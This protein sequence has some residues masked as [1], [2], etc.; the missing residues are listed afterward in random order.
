[1]PENEKTAFTP[2]DDIYGKK[3][4]V[5]PIPEK[6][7]GIDT[8]NSF[9]TTLIDSSIASTLDLSAF[10]SF[11]TTARSRDQVYTLI[12]QMSEDSTIAAVL[13][14]YAE[15]ATETNENG[16]I[17]WAESADSDISKYINYLLKAM[18]V[19]KNAYGW[20]HSLCKY[21]DLYL[22]LYRESEYDD[23]LLFDE[24]KN[25]V[26][27]RALNEE[28]NLNDPD[29]DPD[30]TKQQ[31]NED[32]KI[33]A[34]KENDHYVHYVEMIPNPAEMF[35]LTK[36][37]KTY[38]YIQSEVNTPLVNNRDWFQGADFL[39]YSFKRN[40]IKVY[41]AT[42]FV[43]AYLEDNTNRTPEEVRITFD[44]L[45]DE[46]EENAPSAT[47]KVRR[48]QSLLYNIFKIWRELQL[49]ENSILL[50]R[51]T[52]SAVT[53]VLGIEVGDMPKEMV[54]PHLQGVKSLI[55]QKSALNTD[56]SMNEYTNP[57]PIENTVYIPTRNGI[58]AINMQTI[59]GDVNVGELTDLE[60][61]R[62]KLF[63][64]LRVPKQFFGFTDD[65][66]GFSG[67]QSLS[68]ISSRYAKMIIRIQNTIVQA[69]T[70]IVNL[71]LLDRGLSGYINKFNIKMQKPV[72]QD[73]IDRRD[74]LS[75]NNQVTGDIMNLI[76]E[77]IEDPTSKLEILKS[78]LS[79]YLTNPEVLDIIQQEINKLEA[80]AEEEEAPTDL[81]ETDLDTIEDNFDLG[82]TDS[83]G[84][85]AGLDAALGLGGE[86]GEEETTEIETETTGET[87]ADQSL[88]TPASLGLDF[89]D[90]NAPEFQ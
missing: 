50:N 45:S 3:V 43:H 61:F 71:I 78:L 39:R 12:D 67:G 72:T 14:T 5:E 18:R 90:S 38:A 89:T 23:N 46:D 13:E 37:G 8:S 40:D 83:L 76:N 58:G 82:G 69:L 65:N 85:D 75:N 32:I 21:G 59:G 80:Q 55:E 81:E 35:E 47:Y 60:Y 31:L 56:K 68:I 22:R 7:I 63:G 16:D 87:P 77:Y 57:G 9:F 24:N 51:V 36:F 27:N 33:K 64:A 70:D 28:I 19:N 2:D 88:P 42:E 48:G 6:Q 34:Y 86:G 49:L 17:I 62:N 30:L 15:D 66:A 84:T 29:L 79:G 4:K 26:K 52:K 54:Q 73:D 25:K 20:V 10:D 41:Q 44:N 74:N 1:M 11:L 53:R